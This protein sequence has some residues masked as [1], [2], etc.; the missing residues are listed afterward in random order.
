VFLTERFYMGGQNLRGFDFRRAGP[1][2]FSRPIGGE[3]TYTATAEVF[4]PLIA[5]RMEGE[6]RDRELLRW[7]L[8]TD[9]GFLGT[10]I[11]DPTFR[12]M[13]ASSGIGVRIEIPFLEVPIALDLGWPWLYEETDDRRQLFFSISR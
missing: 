10:D 1:K 12:E 2:Q 4:F 11:S 8:F 9:I 7:G 5:T 3:A 6:V 13:R